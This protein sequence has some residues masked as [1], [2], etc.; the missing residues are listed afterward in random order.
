[1]HGRFSFFLEQAMQDLG[2]MKMNNFKTR[3]NYA[4]EV[5]GKPT[6]ESKIV[7]KMKK[8]KKSKKQEIQN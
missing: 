7:N 8:L 5:K 3:H 6:I 4:T 1:M 2:A